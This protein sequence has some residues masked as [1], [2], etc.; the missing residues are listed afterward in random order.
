MSVLHTFAQ[1]GDAFRV[2]ALLQQRPDL[3][4]HWDSEVFTALH[5]AVQ[6]NWEDMIDCLVRHGADVNACDK[7]LLPPCTTPL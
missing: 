1:D 4:D 5:Y 6:G 2:E 3:I 7:S